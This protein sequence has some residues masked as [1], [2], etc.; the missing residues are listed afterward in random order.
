MTKLRVKPQSAGFNPSYRDC[1]I[2]GEYH[3]LPQAGYNAKVLPKIIYI[4]KVVNSSKT[5]MKHA[6]YII[7]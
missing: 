2:A 5:R 6:A 7:N 3:N 1:R 4:R